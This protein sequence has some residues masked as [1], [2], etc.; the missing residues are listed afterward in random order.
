MP[1]SVV[2]II[3]A[4]IA[5]TM[6]VVAT[7]TY[8]KHVGRTRQFRHLERMQA[9]KAG[10]VLPTPVP[11]PGPGAVVA[12][13]AGVPAVSALAA[14]AATLALPTAIHGE[15]LIAMLA[16]IWGPAFFLSLCALATALVLGLW[17]HRANSK[18]AAAARDAS[19]KPAY[20]SD[21]FD[22][23]AHDFR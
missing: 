14:V 22:A 8:A 6:F 4:G 1:H 7:G 11:L 16:M 19:A 3:L 5:F 23:P 10:V 18:A 9:L 20:D 2:V 13:G 17:L 12:I 21:P 15:E